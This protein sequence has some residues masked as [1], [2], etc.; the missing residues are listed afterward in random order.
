MKS[1]SPHLPVNTAAQCPVPI[2]EEVY[3]GKQQHHGHRIIKETQ[4]K[5]G[6]NAIRSATHKEEHIGR[7]L[8]KIHR[9]MAGKGILHSLLF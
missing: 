7:N 9:I 3:S 4:H 1:Y 8:E 6:V 5:D 2:S